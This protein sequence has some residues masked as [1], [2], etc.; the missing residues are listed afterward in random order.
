MTIGELIQKLEKL[1]EQH[2]IETPV[3]YWGPDWEAVDV[4]DPV[5][6]DLSES[7]FIEL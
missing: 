2:G 5:F 3:R 4:V 1:R 7:H 6:N